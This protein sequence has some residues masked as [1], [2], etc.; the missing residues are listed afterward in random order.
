MK[1][2]KGLVS[3]LFY[4]AL[5]LYLYITSIRLDCLSYYGGCSFPYGKYGWAVFCVIIFSVVAK[6]VILLAE[7]I[8]YSK[9]R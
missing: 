9:T 7:R 2:L 4:I 6:A 3:I 1:I 5:L 8:Y